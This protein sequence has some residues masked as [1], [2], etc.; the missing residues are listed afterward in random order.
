MKRFRLGVL[1]LGLSWFVAVVGAVACT[2]TWDPVTTYT[3]GTTVAGTVKYK[4]Y[5]QAVGT[6]V[7]Q[8]VADTDQVSVALVC[9]AGTYWATAYTTTATESDK[10]GI[11]TLRQARAP[12]NLRWTQ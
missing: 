4:L 1:A 10:S 12:V 6:T 7:I 9:P 2:F 3:D 5:F 8:T 11:V